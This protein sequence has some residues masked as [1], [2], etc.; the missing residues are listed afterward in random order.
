MSGF[1][2]RLGTYQEV[3]KTICPSCGKRTFVRFI[4]TKTG[5]ILDGYGRCDREIKCGFFRFPNSETKIIKTI[6][7]KQP[8]PAPPRKEEP[9]T[10]EYNALPN[11]DGNNPLYYF[12]TEFFSEIAVVDVFDKYR[13]KS[14]K[15]YT[16]FPQIDNKGQIWTAKLIKYNPDGHRNKSVAPFWLHNILKKGVPNEAYF[17]FHLISNENTPIVV[18]E[19]EKTAIISALWFN[20]ELY[21]VATGGLNFNPLKFKQ[22]DNQII[23]LPDNDGFERWEKISKI[24]GFGVYPI[25]QFFHSEKGFDIADLIAK[26]MEIYYEAKRHL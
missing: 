14:F 11:D 24:H 6:P 8:P 26:N 4:D 21:F 22:F 7:L 15:G 1:R 12:L 2:Y 19:S 10:I 23:L 3:G 16:A 25:N 18:V 13:I 17:G 5:V 9:I 20:F